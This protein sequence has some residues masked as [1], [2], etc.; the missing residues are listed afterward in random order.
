MTTHEDPGAGPNLKALRRI[1]Y[2]LFA[3]AAVC[4]GITLMLIVRTPHRPPAVA[5]K[6]PVCRCTAECMR[7]HTK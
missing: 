5:K 2:S 4:F 6:A 7:T 1:L 3:A